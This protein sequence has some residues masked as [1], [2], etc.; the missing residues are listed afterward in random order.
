LAILKMAIQVMQNDFKS[1]PKWLNLLPP[2]FSWQEVETISQQVMGDKASALLS[3]YREVYLMPVDAEQK[4][5][6]RKSDTFF[7]LKASI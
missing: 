2:I 7:R 3:H 6:D 4:N 1:K 5:D